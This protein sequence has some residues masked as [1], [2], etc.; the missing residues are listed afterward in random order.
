MAN[1]HDYANKGLTTAVSL[2]ASLCLFIFSLSVCLSVC[3]YVCL[4]VCLFV[5]LFKH[6]E[7]KAVIQRG[8]I[9]HEQIINISSNRRMKK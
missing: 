5:Y 2:A 9:E 7:T 6:F 1:I 4:F 3:M 8:P